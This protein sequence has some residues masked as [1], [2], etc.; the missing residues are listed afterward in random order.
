MRPSAARLMLVVFA[1]FAAG[2]FLS[3]LF[4]N[5]NAVIA[6]DL[7]A[8]FSL[9]PSELG[10]L[11]SAYFLA[12][13]AFQ[14]PLGVLLDRYGPRRVVAGLL[15]IAALGALLFGLA[16]DLSMLTVG[17]ALIG[18]GVSGCLMGAIKAFTLW[19]PPARLATL[20]GLY[21]AIGGAGALSATA[22]VEALLGPFGWR[23]I[24]YALAALALAVAAVIFTAVPEKPLPGEGASLRRQIAGFG[25]IFRSALFWRIALPFVL[26]HAAYMALQGLWLAPWLY[27]I[28]GLERAAVAR[29]LFLTALAY[30]A[31]SVFFGGMSDRLARLGFS[32]LTMYKTGLAVALA[33]LLILASGVT[34]GL[35]ASMMVY[36]FAVISGVLAFS[37]LTGH[38]AQEMSGRVISAAN[39]LLFVASF[40]FQWGIGAVLRL[41]PA[42][43]GRYAPAGY[44][45]ALFALAA[46]H[47]ASLA[48]LLPM[49]ERRA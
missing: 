24:F 15:C 37:L 36:G 5:I 1:P 45:I 40:A 32:H 3:F 23:V 9:A 41:Y 22:P 26:S 34:T 17:R 35:V 27:D 28:G 14:L 31:G 46:L 47:A 13:A 11:T 12:F 39:M 30:T 44:A 25:E 7:G 48:W 2:Y 6:K 43:D 8:D 42:A 18:L 38:F 33:A 29:Y 21:I 16:G 20:N 4:R 49:R 10:L 19:F